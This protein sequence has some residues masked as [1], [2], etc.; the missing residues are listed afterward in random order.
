MSQMVWPGMIPGPQGAWSVSAWDSQRFVDTQNTNFVPIYNGKGKNI[1]LRWA[2]FLDILQEH[3]K[4]IR[5][6][7]KR[8]SKDILTIFENLHFHGHGHQL[9]PTQW[10]IA[11]EVYRKAHPWPSSIFE[12]NQ[13]PLLQ[14]YWFHKGVNEIVLLQIEEQRRSGRSPYDGDLLPALTGATG[15]YKKKLDGTRQRT[16]DEEIQR[17]IKEIDKDEIQDVRKLR[18]YGSGGTRDLQSAIEAVQT[19]ARNKR[20]R[21]R[22][23]LFRGRAAAAAGGGSAASASAGPA[24]PLKSGEKAHNPFILI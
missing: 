1:F 11:F 20:Q 14:A 21:L 12:W 13:H 23:K 2:R 15:E 10:G 24:S 5:L 7:D 17:Q 19:N 9:M 16:D 18:M 22:D 4:K 3:L 6:G 8:F